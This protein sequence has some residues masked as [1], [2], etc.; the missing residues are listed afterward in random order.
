MARKSKIQLNPQWTAPTP[1][2]AT[3]ARFALPEVL[4][5]V[6]SWQLATEAPRPEARLL[7]LLR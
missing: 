1:E 6:N 5:A 4:E 2:A 7:A 3:E